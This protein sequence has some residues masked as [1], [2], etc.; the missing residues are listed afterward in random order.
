[1]IPASV[2]GRWSRFDGAS[3]R[4]FGTGLINKTF[5]VESASGARAIFQRLH[6]VFAGIVNE[7]IDAVTRHLEKKGMVTP[8][9]LPADDGSLFVE[10]PSAV[11]EQA[12]RRPWRALSFV[13]G[14]SVDRIDSPARAFEGAA[15]VARFH[16]AVSD[17]QWDY[18]HVRGGVHDIHKHKTTLT[19]ALDNHR[20]HRLF[21]QVEPIARALLDD[22][23]GLPDLARLPLRH[24]HGDLKISNVLFDGS[25]KALCLVDLD[26]LAR[27]AWPFEMGDALRSWCNPAGEDVSSATVDR[28][29]FAAAVEGY[30]SGKTESLAPE[31]RHHLVDGLAYICVELSMRF[32]ADA[33]NESYFGWDPARFPGRGEHNLLRARGQWQLAR[34]VAA[35]RPELVRIVEQVL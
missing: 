17:L 16:A 28:Q 20:E 21:A 26:T 34:S 24:C 7:D 13:D 1:M 30:A 4:P 31:E 15:L 8:R 9:V 29:I 35:L 3:V 2:L 12:E 10:E 18:K 11:D 19:A 22:A 33:L 6:P 32:L 5:L 23:A 27:M 14:K 25:G